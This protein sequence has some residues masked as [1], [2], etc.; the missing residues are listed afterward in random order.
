MRATGHRRPLSPRRMIAQEKRNE[1][2]KQAKPAAARGR[3]DPQTTG[4]SRAAGRATE[5]EAGAAQ[6]GYCLS[7]RSA[8]AAGGSGGAWRR[9]GRSENTVAAAT[10]RARTPGKVPSKSGGAALR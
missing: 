8:F 10:Q 5:G 6:A 9:L 3:V 1:L 2:G 7:K 4:E